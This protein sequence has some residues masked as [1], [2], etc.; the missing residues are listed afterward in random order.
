MTQVNQ[1]LVPTTLMAWY[2]SQENK[3]E[4]RIKICRATGLSEYYVTKWLKGYAEAKKESHIKVLA[5]VSGIPES[6]LFKLVE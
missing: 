4:V 3:G 6:M 1:N 5:E 2:S